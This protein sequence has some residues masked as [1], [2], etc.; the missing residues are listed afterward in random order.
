[1]EYST[2]WW[3]VAGALVIAELLTG[4]FYLLMLALGGELLA[5][6]NGVQMTIALA[7]FSTSAVVAVASPSLAG[8]GGASTGGGAFLEMLSGR[9]LPAIK[10]LVR[11]T[12]RA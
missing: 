7:I 8:A 6:Q 4:S 12:V 1:M 11:Q 3:L 9:E 10:A 2:I 5:V